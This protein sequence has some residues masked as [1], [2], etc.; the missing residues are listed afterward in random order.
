M[1]MSHWPCFTWKIFMIWFH[2][3]LK[4]IFQKQPSCSRNICTEHW[5]KPPISTAFLEQRFWRACVK[6]FGNCA[7][8]LFPRWNEVFTLHLVDLVALNFDFDLTL[9]YYFLKWNRYYSAC[10]NLPNSSCHLWKHKLVPSNITTLYF[11]STNII[12]FG[13]KQPIKM[14]VFE[15]FE[16]WGQNLSNSSLSILNWHVSS[17]SN[18]AWFFIVMTHNFPVNF[19]LIYFLLWVKGSHQSPTF[20]TFECSGENLS[21]S[22]FLKAKVS[23]PSNFPSVFSAIKHNS[24]VLCKLK[25]YILW[26]K[27]D[28]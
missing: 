13:Q 22:S 19:K 18:S 7:I 5:R 6:S 27:A 25:H 8:N 2:K 15:I 24:S 16:C 10:E 9:P 28:H 20:E 11:L 23:F 3:I 12:C 17:Y 26:S 21:N 4:W 14:Q 1:M